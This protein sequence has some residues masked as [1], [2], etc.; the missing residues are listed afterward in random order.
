[1]KFEEVVLDGR[2][3]KLEPL[4]LQ[5]KL[6][7]CEVITDGELWNILHNCASPQ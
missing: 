5:H 4:S 6:G 1:M 7:L 2:L 3:V